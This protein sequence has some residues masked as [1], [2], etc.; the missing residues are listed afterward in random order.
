MKVKEKDIHK[1][2]G[3]TNWSQLKEQTDGEISNAAL[4]DPDAKLL[5]DQD[6][7]KMKKPK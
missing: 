6:L 1:S 7:M 2:K 3:K 5:K 4:S